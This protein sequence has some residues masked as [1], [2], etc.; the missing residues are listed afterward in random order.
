MISRNRIAVAL[1]LAAGA[2]Q[3]QDGAM[4]RAIEMPS[5]RALMDR[6]ADPATVLAPFETDGC[7]GGLSDVW[8][9]VARTFPGFAETFE[10]APPWEPCCVTHDR[11][12]HDAGGTT[13]PG[14]SYYARLVADRALQ[15]CVTETGAARRTE[16]ATEYGVTPVQVD[17]AYG[18]IA[19]AMFMAVR[20]GGAPCSGLPWRWGY[21]WPGC[22]VLDGGSTAGEGE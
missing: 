11:A 3:A 13:D 7:S 4:S 18:A 16:M 1:V 19:G 12:Y 9:L 2:A 17:T 22:S 20:F 10:A 6:I 8:R 15:V 5:H 14:A 21:G